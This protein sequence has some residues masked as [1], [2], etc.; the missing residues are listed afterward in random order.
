MNYRRIS[1]Y[2]QGC[3]N[4]PIAVDLYLPETKEKVPVLIR[5][6]YAPRRQVMEQ[7]WEKEAIERFLGA[8]YAVAIVEVRGSG[9]SYGKPNSA[10]YQ[11][12]VR[13]THPPVFWFNSLAY[14][15]K[16]ANASYRVSCASVRDII[17]RN[18]PA[19][20]TVPIE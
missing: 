14:F 20:S 18:H 1:R 10:R 7:P 5:A 16:E 19:L 8:D 13:E 12:L 3:D 9:A 11:L 6:G 15:V 2:Y 4:T 17:A